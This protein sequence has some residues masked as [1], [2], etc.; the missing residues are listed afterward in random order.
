[1]QTSD[2]VKVILD[3]L[4]IVKSAIDYPQGGRRPFVF[5]MLASITK[6]LIKITRL[7]N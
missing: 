7:W 2:S 3:L 1:M 6:I 5:M 4:I